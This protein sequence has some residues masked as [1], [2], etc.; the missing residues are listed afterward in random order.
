MIACCHYERLVICVNSFFFPNC[1][2]MAELH[3][4][5]AGSYAL[6]GTRL[7]LICTGA[8]FHGIITEYCD[9][10]ELFNYIV[11]PK[12]SGGLQGCAFNEKQVRACCG[13]CSPEVRQKTIVCVPKIGRK[14]FNRMT[15]EDSIATA[16]VPASA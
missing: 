2:V 8:C 3:G 5:G 16:S 9:G 11:I 4:T 7:L 14:R 10:G 12:E 1:S 15:T 6:A 13:Q